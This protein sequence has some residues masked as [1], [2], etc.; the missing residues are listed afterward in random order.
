MKTRCVNLREQE[1]IA[2]AMG[3]LTT[4]VRPVNVPAHW[5]I[6][7]RRGLVV[8]FKKRKYGT[9]I[10]RGLGTRFPQS[11]FIKCPFGAPGDIL[12]GREAWTIYQDEKYVLR[13]GGRSFNEIS[14]GAIVY[15]ADDYGSIED[16]KKH[17]QWMS[18]DINNVSVKHN[19]W[20]SPAVMKTE[21]ARHRFKVV[22]V[23]V[24]SRALLARKT[25]QA[26][27]SILKWLESF[28]IKTE[29]YW[30]VKIEREAE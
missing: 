29:N 5:R 30:F 11:D 13:H 16:L 24:V 14:D 26:N 22:E 4:I 12:I 9:F 1:A 20:L 25:K 15:K 19:K 27:M 28:E 7:K 6:D 17:V 2:A 3:K 18:D 10:R 8:Y 23:E 21:D